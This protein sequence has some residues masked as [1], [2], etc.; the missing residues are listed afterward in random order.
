MLNPEAD[1]GNVGLHTCETRTGK[2][3]PTG[4]IKIMENGQEMLFPS[5]SCFGEPVNKVDGKCM[6][7]NC[8]HYSV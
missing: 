6:F 3:A 7:N 1:A 5:R 8:S 2:I 4:Q